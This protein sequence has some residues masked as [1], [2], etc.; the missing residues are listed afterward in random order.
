[1]A[2][3]T[4]KG[5]PNFLLTE[6]GVNVK[7]LQPHV[8]QEF[9]EYHGAAQ[10]DLPI[11]RQ[12]LARCHHVLRPTDFQQL[13]AGHG[14]PAMPRAGSWFDSLNDGQ[15]FFTNLLQLTVD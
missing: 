6:P 3:P 4:L 8:P 2:K 10:S 12:V 14:G 7:I 11:R 15:P 9:A 5:S 13:S 1:M